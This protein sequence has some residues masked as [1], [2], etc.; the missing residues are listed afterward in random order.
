MARARIYKTPQHGITARQK[1]LKK[2]RS[3]GMK[4]K[5]VF[6]CSEFGGISDK[7]EKAAKFA[8]INQEW[9]LKPIG[10]V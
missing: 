4:H 10:W 6:E 2:W 3:N 5:T 9:L 1:R 7:A 8:K